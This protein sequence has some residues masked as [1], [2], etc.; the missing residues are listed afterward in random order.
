MGQ[1]LVCQ[2]LQ[3]WPS[4]PGQ[5]VHQL[6]VT[7][8]LQPLHHVVSSQ[9]PSRLKLSEPEQRVTIACSQDEVS[10]KKLSSALEL[11]VW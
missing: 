5:P 1:H 4:I 7:L 3:A 11:I 2:V 9:T 10:D 8:P 6:L